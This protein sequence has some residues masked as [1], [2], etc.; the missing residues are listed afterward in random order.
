MRCERMPLR[1]HVPTRY[2]A[3]KLTRGMGAAAVALGAW[4][5]VSAWGRRPFD[6]REDLR[7]ERRLRAP[8]AL[9]PGS[10]PY[11][12]IDGERRTESPLGISGGALVEV[13]DGPSQI[14]AADAKATYRDAGARGAYVVGPA[15]LLGLEV[16]P[17][18][19]LTLVDGDVVE[20]R[21]HPAVRVTLPSPGVV[22]RFFAGDA[23][24]IE[25]VGRF[26]DRHAT[27]WKRVAV[28]ALA[29][30]GVT[31]V[32]DEALWLSLLCMVVGLGLT[33]RLPRQLA[34]RQ[35]TRVA[36]RDLVRLE[37]RDEARRHVAALDGRVVGFLPAPED[38]LAQAVHR[39]LALLVEYARRNGVR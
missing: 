13:P 28:S 39:E 11:L 36:L 10:A 22:A 32:F 31:A 17:G 33:F 30:G 26:P 1:R 7:L 24:H 3:A 25:V 8:I 20:L 4:L 16:R 18:E 19:R 29:V 35:V 37:I 15:R 2:Y 5:F 12:L 27:W 23:E 21:G 6:L 34:S 9:S 14:V 38:E